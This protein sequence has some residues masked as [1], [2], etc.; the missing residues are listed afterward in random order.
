MSESRI[1]DISSVASPSPVDIDY[2]EIE[3]I[4]KVGGGGQAVV[5]RA[6][7]HDTESVETVAARAPPAVFASGKTGFDQQKVYSFFKK[8]AEW[9]TVARRERE[10]P[11][12]E[13][14]DHIVGVVDSGDEVPWIA[15]EYMDGGSLSER[16]DGLGNSFGLQ[17][18]LWTAERICR[19]I[20][21]AHNEVDAHFDLKPKNVLS[22]RQRTTFG[23]Y[24]K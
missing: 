16:L 20:E 2:T 1:P 8:A 22:G 6:R 3:L 17:E 9:R 14:S 5:H 23:M 7:I 12:W 10:N 11:R 13:D 18:A 21:V 19:G 4:E 24:P 15:M